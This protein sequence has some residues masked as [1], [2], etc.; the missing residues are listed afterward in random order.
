MQRTPDVLVVGGGVIGCAIAHALAGGGRSVVLIDRGALGGEA[1]SA[2]AGVL[3]V[4]SGS[5]MEG[6]RLALRR[7]SLASFASLA[8]ALVEETGVDVEYEVRGVLELCLDE[9]EESAAA[10][11]V[12]ERQAMGLRAEWIDAAALRDVEPCANRAARG[13]ILFPDDA[14]LDGAR[15]VAALAAAARR[16]GA[17]LLPGMPVLGAEGSRE[18]IARVRVG[19]EWVEPGTVVL[20]AGAWAARVPGLA[21]WLPVGPARG[22]MLALR[23][24]APLSRHVLS[25]GNAYLVPRR[26]GE[27]LV[28]ATIEHVGYDRTVTPAGMMAL[29]QRIAVLAPAGLDAPVTRAWAGLR[30][31]VPGASD[32]SDGGPILGRAPGIANLVLACGHHRNG[33][34]LAPITAA[35]VA[36]VLDGTV[37]PVPLEPFL[38]DGAA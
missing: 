33:M 26:S 27:W 7:A 12:A 28:G 3:A 9:P 8:A 32:A 1:S 36:A 5:E 6:P 15:L 2:S 20:A 37:P 24:A 17:E 19:E 35:L 34:L 38:P 30:P 22:Q 29:G 31:F 10:A 18:R 23:P 13:A 14:Q 25:H 21:P 16:R 4:A 11:R